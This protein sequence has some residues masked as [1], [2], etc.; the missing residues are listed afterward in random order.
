MR[1][2]IHCDCDCFFAAVEM[3]DNPDYR[4]IPLAV[5][6][7]SDRRGVI[8]TC[9]YIARGFGVR[10]AMPTKTALRLC[11]DL[12]V[13]PGHMA[14]Y[15]VVSAQIMSIYQEVTDLI[16][17]LSLDEAYLDVSACNLFSGSGTRIA[18]W[19]R[20]QVAEKTGITISAGVAPN[21]FLA[22]IAS[23]WNKPNGLCVIAPNNV[24][25]FLATLPVNK[26]HGVGKKTAER[27]HAM[28]IFT[29]DDV[30]GIPLH[31]LREHFGQFGERLYHLS[32]GIDHRPVTNERER[33]SISVEHTFAE[34]LM[35]L[36]ECCA[37]IPLLCGELQQ[38]Y[39]KYRSEAAV[40]GCFV[41][42]KFYD[43]TQTTIEQQV[44]YEDEALFS[45]LLVQAWHRSQKPVRLLGIGYRLTKQSTDLQQQ[46]SLW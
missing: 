37:K 26:L 31:E 2:I 1:K 25:A 40:A 16:E 20:A 28:S 23:D 42:V 14:K 44:T 41:K 43:F 27:L 6:G 13:I 17:P 11:P 39:S 24:E 12:K 19:L 3:R 38:R 32:R 29:C 10:S 5:G 21:K 46:L 35:T 45:P 15:R 7:H 33:K 34:D 30:K 36:D 4:D 18:Q 8:A 9:N 22:K